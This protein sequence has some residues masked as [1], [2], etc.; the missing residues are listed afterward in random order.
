M[1]RPCELC[2]TVNIPFGCVVSEQGLGDGLGDLIE[3]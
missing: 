2:A 1:A 3:A